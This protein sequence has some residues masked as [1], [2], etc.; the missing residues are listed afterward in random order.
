MIGGLAFALFALGSHADRLAG[1]VLAIHDPLGEQDFRALKRLPECRDGHNPV[2]EDST[3][4]VLDVNKSVS[5]DSEVRTMLTVNGVQTLRHTLALSAN[6]VATLDRST[7]ATAEPNLC[8]SAKVKRSQ[9]FDP[10]RLDT[11]V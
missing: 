2:D 11:S 8:S 7:L 5:I 4:F 1:R 3:G 9:L 6:P 10:Y